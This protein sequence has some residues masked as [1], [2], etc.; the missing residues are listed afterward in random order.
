M[1]QILILSEKPSQS[2][3]IAEAYEYK[4]HKDHLEI[5]PCD[6][7]RNGTIVVHFLCHLVES[8][9]PEDYSAELKE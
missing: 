8:Y 9:Y 3:K 5:M 7:F 1:G 4:V 2:K 6:T